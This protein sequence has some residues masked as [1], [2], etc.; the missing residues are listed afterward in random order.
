MRRNSSIQGQELVCFVESAR[1]VAHVTVTRYELKMTIPAV[2]AQ[3][4]EYKVSNILD[5]PTESLFGYISVL[6]R[7]M[8]CV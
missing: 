1:Q 3:N 2:A 8:Q 6:V 5:K 4:F 7:H